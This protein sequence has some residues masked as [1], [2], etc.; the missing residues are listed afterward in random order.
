MKVDA[1]SSVNYLNRA[2]IGHARR[3]NAPSFAESPI[4]KSD[5]AK[6]PVI[7]LLAMN[8][9]TLNSAVPLMTQEANSN[10]ITVL[11]PET[12]SVQ[13]TDYVIAPS[14]DAVEQSG[15]DFVL[16]H[17]NPMR[18]QDFDYFGHKYKVVYASTTTDDYDDIT[19]IFF[20][21]DGK[22]TNPADMI[23]FV[24]HEDPQTGKN[25]YGAIIRQRI[26]KDYKRIG[27]I[28]SEIELPQF[29]S[30]YIIKVMNGET[31]FINNL[32]TIDLYKSKSLRLMTSKVTKNN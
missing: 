14:V 16:P 29:V 7:V 10:K 3:A 9:A 5:L 26:Y 12:K 13:N 4:S 17:G 22:K 18:V 2:D 6:V 8:P 15:N 20:Y 30:D 28:E 32:S 23:G 19:S 25:F 24:Y 27:T 31:K 21:K 1:V 11:A